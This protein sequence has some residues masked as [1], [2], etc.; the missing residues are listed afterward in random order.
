MLPKSS[1]GAKG[2]SQHKSA[3]IC[4]NMRGR[5]PKKGE[6]AWALLKTS[7]DCP[8]RP[9]LLLMEAPTPAAKD[10]QEAGKIFSKQAAKAFDTM[11][12]STAPSAVTADHIP[13]LSSL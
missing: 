11:E 5:T 7:S 3:S 2:P 10:D 4:L 1:K 6:I 8:L 9:R 12:R 13:S